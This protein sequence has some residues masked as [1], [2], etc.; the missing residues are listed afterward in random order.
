M[1]LSKCERET[2]GSAEPEGQA[3]EIRGAA[4]IAHLHFHGKPLRVP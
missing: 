3:A 2:S 1:A 4:G